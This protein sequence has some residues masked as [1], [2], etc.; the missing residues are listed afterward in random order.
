M[1]DHYNMSVTWNTASETVFTEVTG[2]FTFLDDNVRAAYIDWDD[3]TSNNIEEANYQWYET[4][5]ATSSVSL[6]HTYTATG[7]F[8]PIVQTVNSDGFVSNYIG[9]KSPSDVDIS[10][11]TSGTSKSTAITITDGEA[12]GLSRVENKTLNSGIDNSIFDIEGPRPIYAQLPPL[13]A[14]SS[15][16]GMTFD[17]ELDLSVSMSMVLPTGYVEGA[18]SVDKM[19]TVTGTLSGGAAGDASG[20]VNILETCFEGALGNT[21]SGT[22]LV[23]SVLGIRYKNPKRI[24]DDFNLLND[25]NKIKIFIVASSSVDGFM[26]PITYVSPGAPIKKTED[27]F[28]K[29]T[30]DF[31][32]SRAK[33]SNVGI[34]NYRYDLGKSW[35]NPSLM[36]NATG[37]YFN[38]DTSTTD[39]S[40]VVNY[41]FM[42]NPYGY[43]RL[44]DTP[45]TAASSSFNVA[46]PWATGARTAF[47]GTKIVTDTFSLDDF[48]RFPP[49]YHLARMSVQPSSAAN[50]SGAQVSPIADNKPLIFRINPQGE[51]SSAPNSRTKADNQLRFGDY[52]SGSWYNGSGNRVDLDELSAASSLYYDLSFGPL[53]DA[54]IMQ[55]RLL[56]LFPNKTN[57]IFFNISPHA[58]QFYS[59]NEDRDNFVRNQFSL[60]YLAGDNLNTIKQN[61]YWKP[62]KYKN[63]T[64]LSREFYDTGS[65]K[66]ID[67]TASY[68]KS[69]YATYDMPSDW[70]SVSMND[71]CGGRFRETTTV[72]VNTPTANDFELIMTGTCGGTGTIASDYGKWWQFAASEAEFGELSTS[73]IGA[74]KYTFTITD[75][76]DSD[77]QV[78]NT[79]WVASGSDNAFDG[80]TR[81]AVMYGDATG[82]FGPPTSGNTV[83]GILRRINV[84]DAVDGMSKVVPTEGAGG[85]LDFQS[86]TPDRFWPVDYDAMAASQAFL[87]SFVELSGATTF[88]NWSGS[89]HYPLKLV[90]TPANTTDFV[91]LWDI[92]DAKNGFSTIIKEEDDS[93]YNLNSMSIT[94]DISYGRSGKF[95]EAITRKGKVY[96]IKTGIDLHEINFTSV[97]T[98]DETAANAFTAYGAHSSMYGHLHTLR[99]IQSEDVRIYWDEIQKDGTYVRFWGIVKEINETHGVG[100]P[101]AIRNFDF[102]MGIENIA[103][104]DSTGTLMTDIFPLGGI[105]G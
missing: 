94:S 50:L 79:Y 37:N 61:V 60:F 104:L 51:Q 55:E 87:N 97:A 89:A 2:T 27:T 15:L 73:D 95:Y 53:S 24:T 45:M 76:S 4:P 75:A 31:T 84:Y 66:Y 3:G 71:L 74:Y 105:V 82:S 93:A 5:T 86:R 13:M 39:S 25:M 1:E 88:N 47:A 62:L 99:R 68:S 32:Q 18:A 46:S 44:F 19:I 85:S 33:A 10:P 52:T 8:Q 40:Y 54:G 63:T 28:R 92:F 42:P 26:H 9:S 100:G 12:T 41:T 58:A 43:G 90:M 70:I 96:I 57:K 21:T 34:K 16:S 14:S 69:G 102:T 64:N 6:S 11:Y 98:G 56:M 65:S 23:K 29:A 48:G 83:K 22:S 91:E 17:Y 7:T 101:K 59:T 72:T 78:G 35:F 30:V 49:Q 67:Q 38:N 80:S 81:L 77:S 103:L 20:S 36:W